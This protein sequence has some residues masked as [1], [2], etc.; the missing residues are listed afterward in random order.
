M[1]STSQRSW[2]ERSLRRQRRR[3]GGTTDGRVLDRGIVA[4]NPQTG[5]QEEG[6]GSRGWRGG[7]LLR[8]RLIFYLSPV[9]PTA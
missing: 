4:R 9:C 7:R 8:V 3:G 5:N 1:G 6:D 2:L